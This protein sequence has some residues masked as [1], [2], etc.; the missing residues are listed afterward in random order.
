M[1]NLFNRFAATFRRWAGLIPIEEHRPFLL[2]S[3]TAAEDAPATLASEPTMLDMNVDPIVT[4]D[5]AANIASIDAQIEAALA[6]LGDPANPFTETLDASETASSTDSNEFSPVE[7]F[8]LV[9]AP[10]A[11]KEEPKTEII[12]TIEIKPD[13]TPSLH[14]VFDLIN[15]EVTLR[16]DTTIAVYERLLA[17]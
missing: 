9:A 4:D 5:D 11:V 7:A 15:N 10:D 13:P 14:E 8:G 2:E 12:P 17:A 3:A 1:S 16:S 6:P